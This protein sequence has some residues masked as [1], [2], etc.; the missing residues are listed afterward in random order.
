MINRHI[1]NRYNLNR[2][3]K[4]FVG[5]YALYNHYCTHCF[6]TNLAWRFTFGIYTSVVGIIFLVDCQ[7]CSF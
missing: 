5:C 6:C 7:V 1:P 3:M 2:P 4:V